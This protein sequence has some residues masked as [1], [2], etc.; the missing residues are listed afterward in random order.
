MAAEPLTIGKPK[1]PPASPAVRYLQMAA[2][3]LVAVTGAIL[4]DAYQ[5]QIP[6]LS[7]STPQAT[8]QPA[9]A[10]FMATR[11]TSGAALAAGEEALKSPL[12]QPTLLA[13]E[14]TSHFSRHVP[15]PTFAGTT[16]AIDGASYT[17]LGGVPA[18]RFHL[19]DASHAI[20]VFSMP[21]QPGSCAS[22]DEFNAVASGHPILGFQKDGGL[23][24]IVGDIG[25]ADADLAA[26]VKQLRAQ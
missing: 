6:W 24:A 3:I 17:S 5:P 23:Q 18:V 13:A 11:H 8:S 22:G 9:L 12:S 14:A 10:T 7:S 25:M 1:K 15:V 4:Y 20:T 19:A 16:L 21:E 2:M 26:L